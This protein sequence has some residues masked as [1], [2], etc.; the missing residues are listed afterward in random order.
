MNYHGFQFTQKPVERMCEQLR[1]YL[2][3]ND[4]PTIVFG[5][6]ATMGSKNK[7]P[8]VTADQQYVQSVDQAVTKWQDSLPKE[9]GLVRINPSPLLD[10]INLLEENK[11]YGNQEGI[12]LI[13]KDAIGLG[14]TLAL[15]F[16]PAITNLMGK[17]K[18]NPVFDKYQRVITHELTHWAM[19]QAQPFQEMRKQTHAKDHELS[20][21]G[22]KLE[23]VISDAEQPGGLDDKAEIIQ[24]MGKLGIIHYLEHAGQV[25]EKALFP[26]NNVAIYEIENESDMRMY[27]EFMKIIQ[28]YGV[29]DFVPI[30]VEKMNQAW[31]QN[32]PIIRM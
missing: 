4:E 17:E 16:I 6:F 27:Q 8:Y 5:P 28:T 9:S 29:Q 10:V 3:R 32:K 25:L 23:E 20:F 1:P 31:Q 19:A 18:M 21:A 7:K 11:F 26:K 24:K 2:H 13:G 30:C 15:P 14:P 22:K 12:Y